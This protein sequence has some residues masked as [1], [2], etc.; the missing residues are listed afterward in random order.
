[1]KPEA[2]EAFKKGHELGAPRDLLGSLGYAYAQS[3]RQDEAREMVVR[4]EQ[5][6][7]EGSVT[8]LNL[9]YVYAG[10]GDADAAMR[11]LEEAYE[12][13]ISDLVWLTRFPET[14]PRANDGSIWSTFSNCAMPSSTLPT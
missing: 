9:A 12:Q 7:A 3:G 14:E 6:V 4:L 8:P 2:I 13:R 10:L 5:G 11:S 1:M